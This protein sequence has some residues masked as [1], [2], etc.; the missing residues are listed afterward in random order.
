VQLTKHFTLAEFI[1]SDKARELGDK[2]EPDNA[3][4]LD[5]LK[6]LAE[7]MEQ[8]RALFG[9][10]IIVSSGYRNK[11]VNEAVG[12]VVNSDH[13]QGLA[14]DFLPRGFTVA[15]TVQ[16]IRESGIKFDQLID[17]PSWVHLGL[18]SGMRQQ[19]LRARRTGPNGK[20]QY[21]AI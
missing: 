3:Q 11:R 21:T 20:M 4:Q 13:A 12:G 2:N 10:P 6:R 8:V 14:C 7:T 19:V 15:Q 5:N 16:R 17:E 18:G 9:S 1:R